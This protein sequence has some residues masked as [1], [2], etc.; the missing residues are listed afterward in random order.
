MRLLHPWPLNNSSLFV[1]E[2]A[3]PAVTQLRVASNFLHPTIFSN[4]GHVMCH[5]QEVGQR[6]EKKKSTYVIMFPQVTMS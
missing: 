2:L 4:Q 6:G 3:S 1:P 5:T